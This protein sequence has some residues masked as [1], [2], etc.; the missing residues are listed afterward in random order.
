MPIFAPKIIPI[1]FE[2]SIKP[3]DKKAA[4]ELYE[5]D[6]PAKRA[7]WVVKGDTVVKGQQLC[8]GSVDL[9]ELFRV[10]GKDETQKYIVQEVFAITWFL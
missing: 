3:T 5:Y 6:V 10:A 2:S 1:A 7:V 9:A 8:E 4:K